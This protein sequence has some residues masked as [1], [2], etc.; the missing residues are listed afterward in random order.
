MKSTKELPKPDSSDWY[1]E[2]KSENTNPEDIQK[3]IIDFHQ[4]GAKNLYE[5]LIFYLKV[6]FFS[7][8]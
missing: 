6:I 8:S 3:A 5:Y 1:N 2:L 4:I 7:Y